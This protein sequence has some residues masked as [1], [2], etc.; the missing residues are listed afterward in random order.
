MRYVN[1]QNKIL[2]HVLAN[3]VIHI[4]PELVPVSFLESVILEVEKSLRNEQMLPWNLIAKDKKLEWYKSIPMK[5]FVVSKNIIIEF[6]IP[7]ISR[8]KRE[9]YELIPAPM[10]KDE[11]LLFIQ[12][13]SPFIITN[14]KKT[15]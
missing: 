3:N 15:R 12:P 2:E 4:D 9:L 5:T 10:I 6:S 14:E 8:N 11:Y 7:I 1:Y 13:A